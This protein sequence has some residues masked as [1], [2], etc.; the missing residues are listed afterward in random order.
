MVTFS[1]VTEKELDVVRKLAADIFPQTYG[2][3]IS[4]EQIEYMMVMMYSEDSLRRQMSEEGQVFQLICVD[5][6]PCGYFSLQPR[7]DGIV[8]LQK[9]Y[10][11]SSMQGKG[12]GR[13]MLD[14]AVSYVRETYQEATTIQLYVNRENRAKEFYL[15]YGFSII[16][17]RD[18]PIGNGY[19]MNDYV[20]EFVVV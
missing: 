14:E 10:L 12:L 5:G 6:E 1:L 4:A 17:T 7:T 19:F 8:V 11:L 18:N 20:M 9:L 15:R 3:I 16:A 13:A 2:G